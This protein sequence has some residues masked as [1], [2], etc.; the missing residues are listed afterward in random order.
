MGARGGRPPAPPQ[1]RPCLQTPPRGTPTLADVVVPAGPVAT[2]CLSFVRP[3]ERQRAR[4]DDLQPSRS[5]RPRPGPRAPPLTFSSS[6]TAGKGVEAGRG[7][8]PHHLLILR[9]GW[10]GSGG[11]CTGARRGAQPKFFPFHHLLP[12]DKMHKGA[13][14]QFLQNAGVNLKNRNVF[15]HPLK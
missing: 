7:H 5:S 9:H 12:L 10:K 13:P 1:A 2:I 11:G 15:S 14:T 8:R 4:P 6:A 3:L